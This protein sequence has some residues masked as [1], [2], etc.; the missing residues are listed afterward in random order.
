VEAMATG[1]SI[2]GTATVSIQ[3]YQLTG[4]QT[5]TVNEGSSAT[6]SIGLTSAN[7]FT[8][9]ATLGMLNLPT[10]VTAKFS[11][12]TITA[13][14]TSVLTL[15]ASPT[16]AAGTYT[17]PLVQAA[18]GSYWVDLGLYVVVGSDSLLTTI[19]VLPDV[20]S[21]FPGNS[22]LFA[23]TAY[24]HLGM[25]LPHSRR[26]PGRRQAVRLIPAVPTPHPPP[27]TSL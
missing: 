20:A 4:P 9:S 23:A 3:T 16:A 25:R 6:C 15:T 7:G 27:E 13:G 24:D 5:V 12:A 14:G 19:T 22:Q 2:F 26:L 11:P 17:T 10:G 21:L 18:D 8:G 1:S